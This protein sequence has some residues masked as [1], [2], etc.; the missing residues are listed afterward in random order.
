VKSRHDIPA[1]EQAG[2]SG[3]GA[4]STPTPPLVAEGMYATATVVC[5]CIILFVVVVGWMMAVE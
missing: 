5:V 2:V 4:S 3:V 1:S